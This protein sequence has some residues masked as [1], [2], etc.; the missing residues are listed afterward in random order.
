[1]ARSGQ[2]HEE[3]GCSRPESH[4]PEALA[5]KLPRS[6]ARA[7]SVPAQR[8]HPANRHFTVL[9]ITRPSFGP[10]A[11]TFLIASAAASPASCNLA[12][13]QDDD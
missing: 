6:G 5:G 11:R 3:I 1:M 8:G 13:F 4:P 12:K 9:R 2:A 10:R 7:R